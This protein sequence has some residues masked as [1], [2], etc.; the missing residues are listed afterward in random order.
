MTPKG[1]EQPILVA[2][3]FDGALNYKQAIT[4]SLNGSISQIELLEDQL[5]LKV[6]K[7]DV[8][9]SINLYT[10][11]STDGTT[12]G[13]KIRGD[14]IDLQGQVTFSSLADSN[15][16]GSIKSIFTQENNRTV[17]NGGMIQTNTIKGN[18]L[19]LKGNLTVTKTVDNKVINTFAIKENGDI[20]IDGILKSSNFSEADNTGYKISTD[21]KAILNQALIKGDIELP[22]AGMTNFGGTVGNNNL[23]LNSNFYKDVVLSEG[24]GNFHA[25]FVKEHEGVISK[26]NGR[27]FTMESI[28]TT[29]IGDTYVY[30]NLTAAVKPLATYT[31]SFDYWAASTNGGFDG[32]SS[33][34][35]FSN[36]EHLRLNHPLISD[37]QRRRYEQT[38]TVPAGATSVQLRFGMRTVAY[39]WVCF[40]GVKLEEGDKATPW[41]PNKDEQLNYIRI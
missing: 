2:Q 41:C 40:D 30:T 10:Q 33:Y 13:V 16:A 20:E 11:E 36:G 34:L 4:M 15:V 24:T 8:I 23:F 5:E 14:K 19:N 32:A 27:I 25:A 21:G 3:I 31:I 6:Q 38:F 18:D 26:Y 7:N 39:S 1:T 35:R 22:N 17:I 28:S 9:A 12:S 37:K 29:A